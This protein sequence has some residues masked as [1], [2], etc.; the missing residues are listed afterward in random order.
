MYHPP[1][2]RVRFWRRFTVV[3]IMFVAVVTSVAILT[4]LTLGYGFSQKDGKIEQGGLL[5]MSSTPTGATVTID[6]V[7]FGSQTPTKLVSQ[8][9]N[10]HV[11]M[12]KNGYH[13]WQKTV[14]IQAGN[15]TWVAYPRLIP[16]TLTPKA[17]VKYP[18]TT[19]SA[20]PSG[21]AKR[22]AVLTS[23]DRPVVS[24]AMLDREE[25]TTKE[26][27]LPVA[28]YTGVPDGQ[29]SRFAI[30]EWTG[31]EKHV[32]L[33]H[34]FGPNNTVEWLLFDLDRPEESI[35]INHALGISGA[36]SKL[37]FTE[38][39]GREIYALIDGSVRILDLDSQTQSRP[40]VEDVVDFR[41]SG[42]KFVL[43]TK[44][45]A[46]GKQQV[47]YV[48]KDYK[49]P[50]IVKTVAHEGADIA[51]FDVG[52]YYDKYYFVISH[53]KEASLFSSGS[54][55]NDSTSMLAL[56]H[57]QTLALKQSIVD[58]NITDN[59][60]FATA[61][62]GVGFATFNLEIMKLTTAQLTHGSSSVPQKL[63]YLD[64]YML[65]GVNDDKLRTYEFDGENQHDIMP[66][67]PSLGATLS[68]S[69]KYLYGFAQVDA[70]TV[71]LTR[72][73]LLDI[74]Q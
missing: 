71:A 12:Q 74:A 66:I 39:N 15:I 1:S 18:A 48:K 11:E 16:Q 8:V 17:T 31:D 42:D 67:I 25:V 61:Q 56:K 10:Y 72:V 46:D 65:W 50:R 60:Q 19:A 45:P 43:F 28:A 55:P 32:L 38:D 21:S 69:G 3:S 6:G 58:V 68:P 9:G 4:A 29:P 7:K 23:A 33:Q 51:Q 20:L 37:V 14:P 54:L 22:Y 53:G 73:Q 26:Y 36:M 40:I 63:K 41:L 13:K 2:K 49:Q 62:D 57:V 52:K 59:G 24:V 5:Q 35:N 27:E 44:A 34:T 47:G 70:D 64:G 30:S